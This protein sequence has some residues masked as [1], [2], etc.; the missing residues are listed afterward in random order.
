MLMSMQIMLIMLGHLKLAFEDL[1][2]LSDAYRR[3]HFVNLE[4]WGPRTKIGSTMLSTNAVS[5]KVFS[6]YCCM[7]VHMTVGC[8]SKQV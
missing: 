8:E 5:L 2:V 7:T 1:R 4:A 6:C 3:K